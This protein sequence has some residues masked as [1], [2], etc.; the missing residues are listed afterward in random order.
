MRDRHVLVTGKGNKKG[1]NRGVRKERKENLQFFK[2]GT[3][4]WT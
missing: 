1:G 4:E 2:E 3:E